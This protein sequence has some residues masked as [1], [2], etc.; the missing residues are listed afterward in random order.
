MSTIAA[1]D[2]GATS[3]RINLVELQNER[4]TL[5]EIHRFDNTPVHLR[6]GIYWNILS[7]WQNILEGLRLAQRQ[8]TDPIASIGVDTWGVDFALLGE[9]GNLI[10]TPRHYRD[11]R[12]NGMMDRVFKVV[13]AE[14]IYAHTG[15]QFMQINTLYQ[16]YSMKGSQR[17]E[18][19]KDLLTIPDLINYWLTGIK[20]GE[21]TIASTTQL[22][23]ASTRQWD[24]ELLA[25]LGLPT[26]ILPPL[27]KP[28]TVLGGL[29]PYL[30]EQCELPADIQVV[31]PAC[32]DTASA[33]ATIPA[34]D[35]FISSG[36][37]SL[38]GTELDEPIL[39]PLAQQLGFT[40]ESGIGGSV[41]FLKNVA[42]LW[43][44]L[45]CRRRWQQQ[46]GL[47]P[48]PELLAAAE[49]SPPFYSLIDPDA[50][51]F[52]NPSNMIEAI[53]RCCR[54]A[55]ENVPETV[56]ELTRC[57]LE[58][59]ALKYRKV[60]DHLEQ[61][62]GRTFEKVTIVGGGSQNAMLC[63]F[64]ANACQ[65]PV[66]AGL[67]E[68]TTLGN[69][70]MQM[71]AFGHLESREEGMRVIAGSSPLQTYLPQNQDAWENA[72]LHFLEMCQKD[73]YRETLND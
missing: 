66:A 29:E 22:L 37:W 34:G 55:G 31:A 30:A 38:V 16:L 49:N 20:S 25:M 33:F 54:D 42:G 21:V 24:T 73:V 70:M 48:W 19:A 7:I 51:A 5:K 10:G 72:Y 62:T 67:A 57:Y 65:R 27:I 1:I 32:H 63:Q 28:G 36:T 18:I 58:S 11:P 46:G 45:E 17:L 9:D 52:L 44:L 4:F 41:R 69:A 40:N 71:V 64:T 8:A 6:G 3:G 35:M 26:S 12:N 47:H 56:G 15:V 68:A 61:A 43:P 59:L 23:N 53:Q 50:K 60:L 2:L 13:P 39:T 14:V